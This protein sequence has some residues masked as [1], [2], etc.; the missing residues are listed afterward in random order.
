MFK[1]LIYLIVSILFISKCYGQI[2]TDETPMSFGLEKTDKRFQSRYL[3]N[4]SKIP[5]LNNEVLQRE[6]TRIEKDCAA[7][8]KKYYRKE[9]DLNI[10][11]EEQGTKFDVRWGTLYL[12]ELS[13]ETAQ[14]LQIGINNFNLA[15]GEKV[16]IYSKDRKEVFGAFTSKNN[17]PDDNFLSRIISGKKVIIE[18][19][20]PKLTKRKHKILLISTF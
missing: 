17:N 11:I 19:F 20:R 4:V 13:S 2:Q 7:C 18:Y 8:K 16:F 10:N 3:K 15:P 14:A 1:K 9:I 5:V 6:A 12:L